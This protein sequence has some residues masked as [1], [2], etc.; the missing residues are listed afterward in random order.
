MILDLLIFY[1]QHFV[2]YFHKIVRLVF[3]HLLA[4]LSTLV[5]LVLPLSI[6]YSRAIHIDFFVIFL[7]HVMAYYYLKGIDERRWVYILVSSVVMGLAF[8]QEFTD[9]YCRHRKMSG[10]QRHGATFIKT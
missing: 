9:F 10:G 3:G 2:I 6:Y 1:F 7:T 4:N 5:Y 8:F